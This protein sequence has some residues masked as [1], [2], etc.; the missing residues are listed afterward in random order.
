MQE[1]ALVTVIIPIYQAEE[2]LNKCL[3]T[4]TQQTYGKLEIV[5]IDDGSTDSSSLI[6]DKWAQKDQRIKVIHQ[7][8]GGRSVARNTGL[9][10]ATGD[11]VAFIDPDDWMA[12]TMIEKLVTSI[13]QTKSDI[14]ICQFINVFSN[15]KMRRNAA[16]NKGQQV[17]NRNEFFSYLLE[18]NVITNHLWRMLYKRNIIPKGIFPKGMDFEDIFAMP[19]I[20]KNCKKIVYIDDSEYFYRKNE[21]SLVHITDINKY[22]DHYIA[23]RNS[24]CQIISLEPSLS[25][26]ANIVLAQKLIGILK[27]IYDN[28]LEI[29]DNC[30]TRKLLKNIK[31]DIAKTHAISGLGIRDKLFYYLLLRFPSISRLYFILMGS[32]NSKLMKLE[33]ILKGNHSEDE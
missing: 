20:I 9:S 15:G 29:N 28:N 11:Y 5:L 7:K 23:V 30:Q 26:K 18:D 3:T 22:Q 33:N 27:E 2:Y 6:C 14:A 8:N 12:K 24:C 21:E 25:S 10:N 1:N 32:D 19:Y 13:D 4:V 31:I 16:F 17:F